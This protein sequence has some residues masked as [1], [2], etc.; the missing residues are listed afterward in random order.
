MSIELTTDNAWALT[1]PYAFTAGTHEN[2]AVV[3]CGDII[4][5][6]T[7]TYTQARTL[8]QEWTDVRNVLTHINRRRPG[9]EA[10]LRRIQFEA[11]CG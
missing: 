11:E 4:V 9:V 6:G 2:R 7:H 10:A 5:Q 1:V 8:A 3:L